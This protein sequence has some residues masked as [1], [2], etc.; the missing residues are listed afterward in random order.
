MD[1]PGTNFTHQYRPVKSVPIYLMPQKLY[2]I[3][4]FNTKTK[5]NILDKKEQELEKTKET[6]E[7]KSFLNTFLA[8][9]LLFTAA[10]VTMIIKVKV[11]LLYSAAQLNQMVSIA[12]HNL[13]P[14]RGLTQPWCEPSP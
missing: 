14:G 11:L 1:N 10:L 12:L 3:W 9:I 2:E 4:Q 7:F 6:P 5:G 8:D 13:T